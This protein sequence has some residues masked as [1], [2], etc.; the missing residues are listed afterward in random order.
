MVLPL[1]VWSDEHAGET[2]P[3]QWAHTIEISD[4]GCRLGGLRSELAP[5]QTITLQRG[6]KKAI[7]RVIW[8]KHLAATE[9][10]AGIEAVDSSVSIWAVNI[11]PA[12]E[13]ADAPAGAA[14]APAVV[15]KISASTVR[16]GQKVASG[17]VNRRMQ[18]GM[19]IA[20]LLAGVALG[21]FFLNR[22]FYASEPMA[23]G[24]LA[25]APPTAQDFARLTP[26]AHPLPGSLARPLDA[27]AARVR[28]AEAPTGHVVYPVSPDEG[29]TGKVRLQIV[30]ASDGLVKQIHVLSGKQP[31]AEAAARAVRLWRYGQTPD[32]ATERETSV[33]VSFLADAVSLQFP[34]ANGRGNAGLAKSN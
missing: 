3:S 18:M 32:V 13:V 30:V 25:P 24:P 21:T 28:V 33:T 26:K 31:L 4:F 5:G 9:N 29:I 16:A 11:P 12:G 23:L 27:S 17:G 7:F 6:Q 22:D 34:S 2:A 8:S 10:Q 20:L 15:P 19:S 14:I 1:R